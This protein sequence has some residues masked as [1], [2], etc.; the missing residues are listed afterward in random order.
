MSICENIDDP[1]RKK[2][3]DSL[4]SALPDASCTE[5]ESHFTI[6]HTVWLGGA[7]LCFCDTAARAQLM[8]RAFNGWLNTDD[9]QAWARGLNFLQHS[10][11]TSPVS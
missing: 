4:D 5:S 11:D 9:G 1:R 10:V 2:A 8:T 6:T 3:S 7:S